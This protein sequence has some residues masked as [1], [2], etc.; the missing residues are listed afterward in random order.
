VSERLPAGPLPAPILSV[1]IPTRDRCEIL[2]KTLAALENNSDLPPEDYEVLVVDDGS[3]DGTWRWLSQARYA[4]PLRAFQLSGNGP[5]R[6]RNLAIGHAR[7]SRVLLLGDDT[8]P[9]PGALREHALSP[10]GREIGIQG[11]IEWDPSQP[12]SPIMSFLAPAG[13]Q[14]YF[15]GLRP[16]CAV[17]FT[18]VLGSNLSAPLE[19][20][21]EDPYDEGFPGAAFEDTELAFRWHRKRKTVIYSDSAVC[22]HNHVYQTLDPFLA[23][24]RQAGRAARYASRK[25]PRLFFRTVAQPLAVGVVAFFRF[26]LLRLLGRAPASSA[27]D[28]RVRLAF[29]KGLLSPVSASGIR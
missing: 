6:A 24:Q 5:A 18:A 16:G 17:P 28:L 15:K 25:H 19:W 14:F 21:R 29:L 12:I 11:L 1:I 22:W 10:A 3:T 7:G 4:Y 27:W 20:F 26:A 13:P 23:R 8:A 2:K 9:R